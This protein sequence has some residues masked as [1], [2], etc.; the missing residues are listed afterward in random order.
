MS[1]LRTVRVRVTLAAVGLFAVALAL[2]SFAL[3]RSVHDNLVDEIKQTNEQQLEAIA[4]QLERG[5]N[6]EDVQVPGGGRGG[7]PLVEARGPGGLP[8]NLPG[9]DGRPQVRPGGNPEVRAQRRV[10]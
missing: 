1:R 3:V 2:A 9:A 5:V 8:V 4:L 10:E 6:P 7:T